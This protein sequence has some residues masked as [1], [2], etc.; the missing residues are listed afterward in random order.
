MLVTDKI[1][2]QQKNKMET[3]III[4]GVVASLN[5]LVVSWLTY[6]YLKDKSNS[7]QDEGTT[8]TK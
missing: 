6:V 4:T 1:K 7:L 5:T 8:D 3:I 2:N